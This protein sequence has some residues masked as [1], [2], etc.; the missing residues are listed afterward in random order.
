MQIGEIAFLKYIALIRNENGA[1]F[2]IRWPLPKSII[3]KTP[4]ADSPCHNQD[5]LPNSRPC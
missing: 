4:F 3:K 2:V 1:R 5:F